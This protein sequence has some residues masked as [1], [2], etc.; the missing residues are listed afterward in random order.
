MNESMDRGMRKGA[1]YQSLV[2]Q[3]KYLAAM[4][5]RKSR[6]PR[7]LISSDRAEEINRILLDYHHEI[8]KAKYWENGHIYEEKTLIRRIDAQEQKLY[9]ESHPID[10]RNLI[11]LE[12]A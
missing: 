7:P 8:L 9:L 2:E 1:P 4:M 3:G 6:V 10:F 5:E 12:Y 11:N